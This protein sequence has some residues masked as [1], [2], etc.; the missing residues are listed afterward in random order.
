MATIERLRKELEKAR[1]ELKTFKEGKN[2][3]QW[4]VELR[5]KMRTGKSNEWEK[6]QEARLTEW[7]TA[8]EKRIDGLL[9]QVQR[10]EGA[11]AQTG[12]DFTTT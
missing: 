9:E 10:F 8:L 6:M 2:E 7:E 4:L 12:N 5:E 3:G 1:G 11:L